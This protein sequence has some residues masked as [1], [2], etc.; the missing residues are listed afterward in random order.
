MPAGAVPQK[1][2]AAALGRVA[3]GYGR[4]SL[5]G[6]ARLEACASR[7]AHAGNGRQRSGD[8]CRPL[9]RRYVAI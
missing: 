1:T 9:Q 6:G 5:P 3:C 7:R 8:L 2:R 4:A